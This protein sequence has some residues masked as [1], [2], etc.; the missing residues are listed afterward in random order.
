MSRE[1]G[2]SLVEVLAAVLV[3]AIIG[4]LSTGLLVSA[5][6]A[7][8]RHEAA[9]ARL[10]S[11]QQVRTL[12]RDDALQMVMR[13]WRTASGRVEPAALQGGEAGRAGFGPDAAQ[14]GDLLVSLTRR[15]RANPEGLEPR[16]GLQRVD[17]RLVDGALVRDAWPFPDTAPGQAPSRIV[18]ATGV[19]EVRIEFR[20]ALTWLNAPLR[21]ESGTAVL[22]LPAALRL[23]YVDAAGRRVEHV[24]LT[25][26][27]EARS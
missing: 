19:E 24:V 14:A 21:A 1:D 20:Y 11:L 8:S 13:P 23:S 7:K 16:S 5:L 4:S 3:F 15:G 26:D 9:L 18:L 6:D 12:L 25:S 2:F 27:G 10:D 22:Q 17:W